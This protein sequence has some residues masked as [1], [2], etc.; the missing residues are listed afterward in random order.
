MSVGRNGDLPK[1]DEAPPRT[2]GI[3]N[4]F[5][6]P[7]IFVKNIS[8]TKWNFAFQKVILIISILLR[9]FASKIY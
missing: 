2:A 8:F 6:I 4:N 1:R 3:Q 7:N 9:I 5:N